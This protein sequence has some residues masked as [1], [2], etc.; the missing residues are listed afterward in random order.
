MNRKLSTLGTAP[1]AQQAKTKAKKLLKRVGDK[2]RVGMALFD[3][4][5][6]SLAK[7]TNHDKVPPKEKHVRSMNSSYIN[8]S[9]Y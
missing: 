8:H 7:A 5:A 9:V 3:E 4:V 6:T 1:D 2:V